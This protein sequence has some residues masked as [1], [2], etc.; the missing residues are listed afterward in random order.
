MLQLDVYPPI[1]KYYYNYIMVG[2]FARERVKSNILI[3]RKPLE[4]VPIYIGRVSCVCVCE[5]Y[6]LRLIAR[7]WLIV[8]WPYFI[9][10]IVT[11]VFFN[12]KKLTLT[13]IKMNWKICHRQ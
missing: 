13:T 9:H 11:K 5:Q 7:H 12:K 2:H 10:K 8:Q 3:I 6:L 1:L 4:F